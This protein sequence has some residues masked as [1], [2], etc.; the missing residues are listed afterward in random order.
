MAQDDAGNGAVGDRSRRVR[1]VVRSCLRRRAAGEAVPDQSIIDAHP[2][3][4]P[5]LAEELRKLRIIEAA[6]HQAESRPPEGEDA[7][8]AAAAGLHIRCPHCHHPVEVVVDTP[9]TDIT[10][11]VCGSHFSLAGD[12]NTYTTPTLRTIGHFETLERVGIGAFGA[13]W[14]ARDTELDRTVALKIPRKGQ[15]TPLESEQFLREARAAAQLRHPN[16]VS[17]YEVGRDGE[18]LYIVS[19]LIRGVSLSEWQARRRL[20]ARESAALCAKITEALH[21][22]HEAGVIH[23]DLKPSNIMMDAAGEPHVM[24][25]GLAK[26]EAGEITV[27]LE[28]R[29][30][31]TPAY[32][33]PEQARGEAHRCDRRSDVYSLGVILFELLTSELPFRGSSRT[34]I[35]QV[36]HDEPPSP[37]KLNHSI[38]RDLETICLKCVQKHPASRY[39]TAQELAAELHRFLRGEA[40]QA[41]PV[42][43]AT[44]VW[45]WCKRRPMVAGLGAIVAALLVAVAVVAT[46]AYVREARL[47][48][49][50][51]LNFVIAREAVDKL[52][53]AVSEDPRLKSAGME[54]LRE[55]LLQAAR[56]FYEKLASQQPTDPELQAERARAHGRLGNIHVAMIQTDDAESAFQGALDL[57][58]HLSDQH[59]DV[60]VYLDGVATAHNNLGLLYQ[61][62]GRRPEAKVAYQKA[63]AIWKRLTAEHR[64]VPDYLSKLGRSY[65]NLGHLHQTGG[66]PGEAERQYQKARAVFQRLVREHQNVPE[67]QSDLALTD[68]RL[69]LLYTSTDRLA[70]AETS[71]KAA[72]EIQ[73]VLVEKHPTPKC[74][75]GLA[76][77]HN[78]LGLLYERGR[79][80]ALA[81]A[82]HEAAM[83]IRE[84]LT[85]EHPDVPPYEIDLAGSC[86]NLSRICGLEGRNDR[87]EEFLRKAIRIQERLASGHPSVPK[88]EYAVALSR[89]NLGSLY[90]RT[91]R[92]GEAE[93]A[94]G[95]AILKLEKLVSE[96]EDVP[97]YLVSL[98]G[99]YGNMGHVLRDRDRL[100]ASLA[101][102]DKAITTL[103]GPVE[104]EPRLTQARQ[105]L[106]N[107]YAGRAEACV[108]LQRHAEAAANWSEALKLT[109]GP[110]GMRNRIRM[111][112]AVALARWGD[113]A[114][115]AEEAQAVIAK[116]PGSGQAL[117]NAA[118]VYA[119]AAAAASRDQALREEKR[120][121]LAEK[122]G[123]RAVAYLVRAGDAGLPDSA[124]V[125][126]MQK[127]PD[128]APLRE[129]EDYKKLLRSLSSRDG[130]PPGKP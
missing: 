19:D 111:F 28:G 82:E 104:R 124:T 121:A 66:Q 47:R 87:A 41:R 61:A 88:Y 95:V 30:L 2:E 79:Q 57:F 31:G 81:R 53:T 127:D 69:G 10:C 16:I 100:E 15:L 106:R 92:F 71:L 85:K 78:N 45:R 128:L 63:L 32:M 49:E 102:Y 129:R 17:V 72:L 3:L 120:A 107:N 44:H 55:E 114:K 122:Y 18:T 75:D 12:E 34:L 117:H 93:A 67:Y 101:W 7:E 94:F 74:R 113:H 91:R 9:L 97:K 62:T 77:I 99:T 52:L 65:S 26:R 86:L 60:P 116:A 40:I 108:K 29:P 5:D 56:D 98:G 35:Y 36:I 83:A 33:S 11:S 96:N 84:K 46:V 123:A 21:H 125:E 115:A 112:R 90:R 13:V 4:M 37:R 25:F 59:R 76:A 103:R 80:V 130:L 118:C 109:P 27:T 89:N 126:Q 119:Q 20:T 51:R 24:D 50:V 68:T 110:P 42:S 43:T 38:P 105:Y 58:T 70:D 39:P 8:T 73:Q 23:R 1:E 22:A 54:R 48:Q 14:K 64:H 6:R